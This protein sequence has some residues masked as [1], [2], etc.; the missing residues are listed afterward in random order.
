MILSFMEDADLHAQVNRTAS[1]ESEAAH[2]VRL[3]SLP[4]FI[5]PSDA[6]FQPVINIPEKGA[7]R[8]ICQMAAASYVGSA[9]TVRPTCKICRDY[10]DG[11]FGRNRAIKPK[12][13]QDGL[14]KTLAAGERSRRF[15]KA[16][17]LSPRKLIPK[18]KIRLQSRLAA[19]T[20]AVASSCSATRACASS[21]TL[22]IRRS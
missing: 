7:D 15:T 19:T 17:T 4:I 16:S 14:T 12:E 20:L 10:F 11:V 21:G 3:N 1:V 22:P 18:K 5:C 8:V 13:L 6:E 2:G 9:G